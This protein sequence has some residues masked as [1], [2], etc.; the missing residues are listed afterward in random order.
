MREGQLLRPRSDIVQAGPLLENR[1]FVSLCLARFLSSTAQH[2][3]YS[4]L[5]VRRQ[6]EALARAV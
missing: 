4:H 3:L 5:W 6:V 1:R 2:A